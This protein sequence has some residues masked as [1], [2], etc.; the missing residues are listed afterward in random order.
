MNDGE[1]HDDVEE[2]R[3]IS[4]WRELLPGLMILLMAVVVLAICWGLFQPQIG[5]VFSN[6]VIVI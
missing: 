4:V 5:N 2:Q 1:P 6:I 3:P